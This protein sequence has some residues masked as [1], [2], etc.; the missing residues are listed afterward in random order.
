MD[1]IGNSRGGNPQLTT[2]LCQGNPTALNP[3]LLNP[4]GD[5]V[6][7]R[8]GCSSANMRLRRG[9]RASSPACLSILQ[10]LYYDFQ[11]PAA[12]GGV[13]ASIRV[14]GLPWGLIPF[15]PGFPLWRLTL[16]CQHSQLCPVLHVLQN[17]LC[18]FC[19]SVPY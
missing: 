9:V 12:C 14:Q 1:R 13:A 10:V 11:Y 3:S 5:H 15:I 19:T 18:T 2:C 6:V 16:I 7:K 4:P 8:T 17:I